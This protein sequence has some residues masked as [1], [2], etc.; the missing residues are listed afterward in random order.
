[1]SYT[2]SV[3]FLTVYYILYLY[4]TYKQIFKH[5]NPY[6]YLYNYISKLYF[7]FLSDFC[8]QLFSGSSAS[9]ISDDNLSWVGTKG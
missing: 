6:M 9:V 3:G 4:Y 5:V 8:L 1:M 2:I 7:M